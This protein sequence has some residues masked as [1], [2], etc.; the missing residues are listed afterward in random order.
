M[1]SA[2]KKLTKVSTQLWN[3]SLF[4]I[5]ILFCSAKASLACPDIDGLADINCD[6]ELRIIAFGDSIT[7]GLVDGPS[8]QTCNFGMGSRCDSQGG[9]PGRMQQLLPQTMVINQGVSGEET[10]EALSRLGSVFAPGE[11]PDY[12]IILEGV[13]DHF[14]GFVGNLTAEDVADNL[15]DIVDA[16]ES[17]GS[18]ALLASLTSSSNFYNNQQG[19]TYEFRQEWIDDVNTEIDPFVSLDFAS[20]GLGVIGPDGLHPDGAGYQTMALFARNGLALASAQNRPD[21]LDNDGIYDFAEA[22]FGSSSSLADTD[23]DGLLDGEEVF[24]F[25][26]NPASADTDGDGFTDLEEVNSAGDNTAPVITINAQGATTSFSPVF[27]ING[28]VN[29]HVEGLRVADIFVTNGSISS[30]VAGDTT[31]SFQVTASVP[32]AVQVRYQNTG[33]VDAAGNVAGISNTLNL[34]YQLPPTTTTT[35]TTTTSSTTTTTTTTT[36]S[37]T[38]PPV[39]GQDS[40][41][42]GLSDAREAE[43]GTSPALADTDGDGADDGE[44]VAFNSDPLDPSSKLF[45]LPERFCAEWNGFIGQSWNITELTNFTSQGQEV[46]LSLFDQSGVQQGAQRV[47]ILPGAQSDA[48]VHDINGWSL[49]SIGT[50]C[51]DKDP[52]LDGNAIDGRMLHYKLGADSEIDY[53]LSFPFSDAVSGPV[54]A[55]FN[56]FNPVS[57]SLFAANWLSISNTESSDQEGTLIVYS[58]SGIILASDPVSVAG[59]GRRDFSIHVYGANNVGLIEW[60]PD[61]SSARFKIGVNRYFYDGPTPASEVS[62]AVA[63]EARKGSSQGLGSVFDTRAEMAVVEVSNT[64]PIFTS[65]PYTVYNEAGQEVASGGIGLPAYA[66]EHLILNQFLPSSLGTVRIGKSSSQS[67]L[68]SLFQYGL[69][70]SGLVENIYKVS[71]REGLGAELQG[72]YNTFLGQGCSLFIANRR[73]SS[74]EMNIRVTRFDG[75]S[76]VGGET[77]TVPGNGVFEYDLCGQDVPNV[78]GVVRVTPEEGGTAAAWVVR[79]GAGN[80]YKLATPVR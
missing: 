44:E 13:N 31:F 2:V 17:A 26:T 58:P 46:D 80:N 72:T 41:G 23:G 32:G 18:V 52:S 60:R 71:S 33:A 10:G 55:Q 43:L 40:D 35:T 48:L 63:T 70:N 45:E 76:V 74:Q 56:T 42:D 61:N 9:Y 39:S 73:A 64:L 66:T 1:M 34:S 69:G 49:N 29:E 28:Q 25:N 30:F 37:S 4:F 21:D 57:S 36:T 62:N 51:V 24:Q 38:L 11:D 8:G 12:T 16:A 78:Y 50:V 79:S 67:L 6:G 14:N 5:F 77:V 20:L 3:F 27:T 65:V 19:R 53:V 47:S 59:L 75:A 7:A 15:F 54:F 22:G 68:V